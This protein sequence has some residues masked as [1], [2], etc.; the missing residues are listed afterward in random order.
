[1]SNFVDSEDE[2][3]NFCE[4][5][6]ID[7][8]DIESAFWCNQ[9]EF[10]VLSLNIQ[11]IKAKFDNFFAIINRLSSLG[12]FFAAICLQETWL[13]SN[14][15]LSLLQMPGYKFIHQ[16]HICSKHG[17]LLIYL[18]ND[19]TYDQRTFLTSGKAYLLT[20]QDLVSIERLLST[21]YTGHLMTTIIMKINQNLS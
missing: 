10:V 4:S 19:F 8:C 21:I 13:T 18:N 5:L 12:I 9:N 17:G 16:G 6:Y 11:S 3:M 14:A 15:D 2:I 1:M 20:F 7:M